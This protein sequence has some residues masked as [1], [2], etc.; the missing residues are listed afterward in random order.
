MDTSKKPKKT[1]TTTTKTK[2]QNRKTKTKYQYIFL[3]PINEL[4]VNKKG[5]LKTLIYDKKY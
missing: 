3:S 2:K 4:V 1:K 5:H